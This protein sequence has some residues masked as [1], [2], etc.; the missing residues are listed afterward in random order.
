MHLILDERHFPQGKTPETL[1]PGEHSGG[2]FPQ[3]ALLPLFCIIGHFPQGKVSPGTFPWGKSS[4]FPWGTSLR[5]RAFSPPKG[6]ENKKER[7]RSLAF[8]AGRS[9][10]TAAA[11]LAARLG[12]A[13]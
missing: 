8:T 11:A 3:G 5:A 4:P 13:A 9:R 7:E 10:K 12:V 1:S 6:G 2:H